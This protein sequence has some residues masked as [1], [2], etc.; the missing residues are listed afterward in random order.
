MEVDG[1]PK[2]LRAILSSL[3]EDADWTLHAGDGCLLKYN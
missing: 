3:R 1:I 2:R